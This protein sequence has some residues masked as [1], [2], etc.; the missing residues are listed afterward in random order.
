MGDVFVSDGDSRQDTAVLLLDAQEKLGLEV[1]VVQSTEG[2]FNVPQ[3]VADKA[4]ADYEGKKKPA[5]KTA[6]KKTAAKK[7]SK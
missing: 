5:K 6:A 2:G 1:G 4:G 3:E 7:S